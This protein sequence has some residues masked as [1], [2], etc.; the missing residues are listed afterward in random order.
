MS[1]VRTHEL[2]VSTSGSRL[3]SF[4]AD[5]IDGLS[6]S[7]AQQLI[8]NGSVLV[9]GKPA[10]AAHRLRAGE[11]IHVDVPEPRPAAL[12]RQ[13]LPLEIL[14]EDED[15]LVLDKPAG[16]AVHPSVGHEDNTLVNALLARYPNLSGIGGEQRPG[17]VHRL[18]LNTSG[19]LMVA[20][21]ELGHASLSAQLAARIVSK[22]YVALVTG[23]MPV[24]VDLIEAPIGRDPKQRQRMAVVN[25]GR[26]ARTRIARIAGLE[27]YTFMLAMPVTGRTHQIRVHFAA[28]G[29]PVVGDALYGGDMAPLARQFLH[30]MALRFARPKDG[31]V[32]ECISELPEDLGT[33]LKQLLAADAR[34]VEPVE[35]RIRRM[36]RLAL[37]RFRAE[38][39]RAIHGL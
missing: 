19:L 5:K 2:Q 28:T 27:G 29:Y 23:S 6:R 30:A 9:D 34:L 3:D 11:T 12:A 22:G 24:E 10:A 18:D 39:D 8:E 26:P 14:Y 15:V 1:D 16:I 37:R 4:L 13:P 38:A 20:K 31:G 35:D 32:V 33:A 7:R 36:L 25:E 21:T 17:I